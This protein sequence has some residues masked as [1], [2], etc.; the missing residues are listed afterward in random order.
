MKDI[1]IIL[2]IHEWNEDIHQ[3]T[4][5]A[6]DSVN[7]NKSNYTFGK[8]PLFIVTPP[9]IHNQV[10][11]TLHKCYTTE[12]TDSMHLLINTSEH[13]D[14]CSQ[15]NFAVNFVKQTYSD[16]S[17]FS[18]LEFDDE[19]SPKWFKM[20]ADY[21][22]GNEDVSVFL[23]VNIL[24]T[25]DSDNFNFVNELVLATSFSNELG[26]IDFDC[27]QNCS[28]FNLTGG[29]FNIDDF[30]SVGGFK[31]SIEVAFNY[32][33][34]LRT[35]SKGLRVMVVPKEGYY[36]IMDRK[37]SLTDYYTHNIDDETMQKW[38]E[39]A[40]REYKFD[41]DRKKGII[42]TKKEILK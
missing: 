21:Y 7:R 32:E 4:I 27:L 3:L 38:F 31:P 17:F 22:N 25:S 2:P 40:K 6:I 13:F 34:L 10:E 24:H 16:C 8:L 42:N 9:D 26:F 11:E 39:L 28:L 35:T 12:A 41:E 36:H 14:F 5:K 23:P 29:I 18:I 20:A 37:G 19:Y 33:F 30:L 1:A 15:I